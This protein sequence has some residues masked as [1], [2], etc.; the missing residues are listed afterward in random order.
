M[1]YLRSHGYGW[2]R[3]GTRRRNWNPL[4]NSVLIN[5]DLNYRAKKRNPRRQ[6][7]IIVNNV[8]NNNPRCKDRRLS[9]RAE[10]IVMRLVNLV[11]FVY[12]A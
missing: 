7:S 6:I 9:K 2:D 8:R 1:L 4:I 11:H 12:M 5:G 3:T 10:V